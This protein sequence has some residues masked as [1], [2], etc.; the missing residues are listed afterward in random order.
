MPLPLRMVPML[1]SIYS[2]IVSSSEST[3]P[4]AFHAEE[5][6][7]AIRVSLKRLWREEPWMSR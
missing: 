4:Y 3:C 5:S 7:L 1:G 2:R 6:I